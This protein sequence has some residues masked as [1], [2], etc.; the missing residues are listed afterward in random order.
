MSLRLSS[1]S[2]RNNGGE[3]FAGQRR[4]TDRALIDRFVRPEQHGRDR[5]SVLAGGAA[6]IASH[7]VLFD[8]ERL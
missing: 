4:E 2:R 3:R 8:P 7:K 6:D 5:E 1:G